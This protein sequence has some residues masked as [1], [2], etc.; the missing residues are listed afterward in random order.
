MVENRPDYN[1]HSFNMDFFVVPAEFLLI[2]MH[3]NTVKT[4]SDSTD[5]HLLQTSLSVPTLR[6]TL[7]TAEQTEPFTCVCRPLC[8]TVIHNTAQNSSDYFPS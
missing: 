5:F 8:T 2:S 6:T 3:D 4:D 7:D 1:G